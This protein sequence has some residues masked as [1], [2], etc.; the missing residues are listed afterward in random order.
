[1]TTIDAV[2][3]S[4]ILDTDTG[5][6]W[7]HKSCHGIAGWLSVSGVSLSTS[8]FPTVINIFNIILRFVP[9]YSI[10]GF[11]RDSVLPPSCSYRNSPGAHP[12][13]NIHILKTTPRFKWLDTFFFTLTFEVLVIVRMVC[14][15]EGRSENENVF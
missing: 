5:V 1:M 2:E 3:N 7:R 13:L 12:P 15:V 11:C 8:L 10:L 9:D 4:C 6:G 14:L